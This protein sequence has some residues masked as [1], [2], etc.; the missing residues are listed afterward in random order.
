MI[1]WSIRQCL[2][3]NAK[4]DLDDGQHYH[5]YLISKGVS[6]LDESNASDSIVH[7]YLKEVL[8]FDRRLL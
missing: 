3:H 7:A 8:S 4:I 6:T 2:L 5:R 1:G